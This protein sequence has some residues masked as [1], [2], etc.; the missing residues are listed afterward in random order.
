MVLDGLVDALTALLG[1]TFDAGR[2]SRTSRR[3]CFASTRLDGGAI[4]ETDANAVANRAQMRGVEGGQPIT[5][6]TALASDERDHGRIQDDERA[7]S[8]V[9]L[10]GG[11]GCLLA[12]G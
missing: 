6:M 11:T 3:R 9:P 10:N 5:D 12:A 7:C 1:G 4:L 8:R 2:A